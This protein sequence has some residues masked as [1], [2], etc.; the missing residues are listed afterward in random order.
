MGGAARKYFGTD[1]IRGEVGK[2]PITPDFFMR[3]G[4]AMGK[5]LAKE[6]STGL[7]LIGK[8][9]RI[10]GYMFESALEAGFSAAGM[11]IRLL[12]PMP[13]P[14]VAFLTRNTRAL[15]GVVISASHNPFGDNGIKFFA[16]DGTKLPR[17]QEYAI[18]EQ[19]ESPMQ[20][21]SAHQ[22]GKVRRIVDAARRYIEFCKSRVAND[23]DLKGIVL[24]LDC[25]NG[26]T[27]HIA[28]KVFEEL[29]AKVICIG[30]NPN[31]LNINESCGACAPAELC[32]MVRES[33]ADVGIALDGDGD[34]L[35]MVDSNGELLNGDEL[36][37]IIAK[38]CCSELQGGVVGTIMSNLG[39][40]RAV[41]DMGLQFFR[42]DVGDR[43]VMEKLVANSL[44]LGW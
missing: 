3:I 2:A 36:L 33:N 26:A 22:L 18:E 9:T 24:V 31:G 8:D 6:E 43:C 42:A 1:G 14:G 29:G 19:L 5:I 20:L 38:G 16:K 39:L 30:D 41:N 25:A 12:G 21:V 7:V 40:E 17:E 4:W 15:A 27:Y 37:Y 28:P 23:I 32:R 34:R 10:S 13:T 35:I 11:D 44:L